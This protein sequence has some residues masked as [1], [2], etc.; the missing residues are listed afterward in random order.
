LIILLTVSANLFSQTD[1]EEITVINNDL[2]YNEKYTVLIS[3]Y[4]V[5]QGIYQK[6][7]GETPGESGQYENNVRIGEWKYYNYEGKEYFVY[8]YTLNKVIRYNY[9]EE[10]QPG[11]RKSD[12]INIH[13]DRPALFKGCLLEIQDYIMRRLM[14]PASAIEQGVSGKVIVGI[15]INE[16]GQIEDYMIVKGVHKS[17]NDEA[18]RVIKGFK[19][20]W[21]PAIYNGKNTK[22]VFKQPV[23]FELR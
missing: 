2:G 6:F 14:Y 21:I 13:V 1:V 16:S 23:I 7:F 10:P 15:I 17:L 3:D 20:E 22:Y 19:G 11:K 18:I 5:K 4:R 8:D 9:V 12:T